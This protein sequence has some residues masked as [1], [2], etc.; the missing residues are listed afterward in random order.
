MGGD[1]FTILLDGIKDYADAQ[2][3]AER[4]K[5]VLEQPFAL[6]GRELFVSASIGIKYSGVT[7]EEPKIYCATPILRCIGCLGKHVYR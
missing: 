1:E 2:R 4:V 6:S 7:G 3:V 5:E